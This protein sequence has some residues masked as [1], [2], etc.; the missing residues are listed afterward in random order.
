MPPL[1]QAITALGAATPPLTP[2]ETAM[3][4][5]TRGLLAVALNDLPLAARSLEAA[6]ASGGL[7]AGDQRNAQ[8]TLAAIHF[9]LKN[10]PVAIDFARK[11]LE[12]GST[13]PET[14]A[15]VPRALYLSGQFDAAARGLE[16]RVAADT[17]AGRVPADDEL[18]MLANSYLE[19]KNEPAHIA[20]LE[21]LMRYHPRPELWPGLIARTQRQPGFSERLELDVYRLRRHL[22]LV[23]DADDYLY[24]ADL[25][26]RAGLP[27]E[28]KAVLDAGVA[29]GQ[30][31]PSSK[32]AADY[33]KLRDSV[34]RA[35]AQD[36]AA[37]SAANAPVPPS[38]NAAMATGM[39]LASIGQTERAVAMMQGALGRSDLRDAEF[40]RLRLAV[41][42]AETGR[43][44][45]ALAALGQ[46]GAA[47]GADALARLWRLALE[48]P[49][50]AAR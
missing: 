28:A 11:A 45:E 49:A 34:E 38:A 15:L 47:G 12:A 26:Q 8:D 37:L 25:A 7:A 23:E 21:K 36:R 14:A 9:R 10:Y 1:E 29:A 35:A 20:A 30:L 19:T 17:A 22:K 6:V 40:A 4:Q 33:R 18:R 3:L 41:V 16:A 39:A 24:M 31:G 5:R 48:A 46:V 32:M 42:L 27:N 13:R 2:F 44:S 43:K 50:A